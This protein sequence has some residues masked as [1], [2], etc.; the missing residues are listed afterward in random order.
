MADPGKNATIH[1]G[2]AVQSAAAPFAC[3]PRPG[4][5]RHPAPRPAPRA[6]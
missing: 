2:A 4:A 6:S 3:L 1:I 5:V